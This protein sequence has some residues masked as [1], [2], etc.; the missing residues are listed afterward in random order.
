MGWYGKLYAHVR[1]NNC[2]SDRFGIAA[3]VRQ[4]GVLSPILFNVYMD[5]L[6]KQ[7]Q[8]SIPG[9]YIGLSFV[10]CIMY[11]DDILLLSP[12][13][14]GLQYLLDVCSNYAAVN[15]IIF[16]KDKSV[17]MVVGNLWKA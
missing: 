8:D 9:C 15:D 17:C 14:R 4:G 13:V 6:F 10:G 2:L 7:L 3:G 16:N 5:D 1:W 12:S 11:A